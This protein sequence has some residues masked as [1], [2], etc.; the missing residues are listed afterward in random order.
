MSVQRRLETQAAAKLAYSPAVRRSSAVLLLLVFLVRL[1]RDEGASGS[2]RWWSRAEARRPSAL[3]GL[4]SSRSDDDTR[5]AVV[6][7]G[8]ASSA[9]WAIVRTGVTAAARQM[10]AQVDYEAPDVYSPRA[11]RS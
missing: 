8:Q 4:E 5:I 11:W 7:H 1:R 3:P 2:S 9:F 10:N 6:T